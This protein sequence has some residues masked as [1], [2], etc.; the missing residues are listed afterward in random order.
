MNL[1]TNYFLKTVINTLLAITSFFLGLRILFQFF[2]VNS[3]TPFVAWILDISSILIYPFSGI[4]PNLKVQPG[5][6]DLVSIISEVVY[7]LIGSL[8]TSLI[9]GFSE[10]RVIEEHQIVTHYHDIDANSESSKK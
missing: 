7:L 8:L 2:S 4:A 6:L 9:D 3:S 1:Q 10:S 5:V